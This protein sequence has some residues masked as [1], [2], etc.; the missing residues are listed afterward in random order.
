MVDM[1]DAATIQR[2][3]RNLGLT[4]GITGTLVVVIGKEVRPGLIDLP[5]LESLITQERMKE[6]RPIV[7][8]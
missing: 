6:D 1:E 5:A 3:E 2:M 7:G 4:L 8:G